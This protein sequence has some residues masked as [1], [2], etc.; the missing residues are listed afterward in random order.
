MCAP[1][2]G[3]TL[4]SL[5]IF[6]V[7]YL[8]PLAALPWLL[9][10]MAR[11]M[12]SRYGL[13]RFGLLAVVILAL[14][15]LI[16]GIVMLQATQ[17]G[18]AVSQRL[19]W[20]FLLVAKMGVIFVVL[21]Q[22]FGLSAKSTFAPFGAWI[23][24]NGIL[25]MLMFFV[26]KPWVA[27]AFVMPTP[28]MSPTIVPGDRFVA[29]KILKPRRWDLVV[30]MNRANYDPYPMAY[31]KR[32]V[33]LPGERLRFDSGTIFVNDQAV[34]VPSVIAGRCHAS[35]PGVWGDRARYAD[36]QT[37]LLGSNDYFFVGDNIDRSADSRID[38]PSPGSS[39]VGVVDL[40]YWTPGKIRILR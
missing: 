10:S 40:V 27:E 28:T 18:S 25:L 34:E 16:C 21:M 23:G 26:I 8:V 36:G 7:L 20:S 5:F 39:I 35:I 3:A 14:V 37:I 13:L 2:R 22:T 6:A 19:I 1:Y 11:A 29:N 9:A 17:T 38:G 15:D 33:G 24:W 31:C 12:G 4:T 30:Y 32:L